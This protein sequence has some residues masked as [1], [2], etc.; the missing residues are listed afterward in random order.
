MVKERQEITHVLVYFKNHSGIWTLEKS[1]QFT[2]V[3]ACPKFQFNV[4]NSSELLFFTQ[5]ELLKWNYGSHNE[6]ASLYEFTYDFAT[7]PKFSRFSA[8]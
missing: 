3:G 1:A 6:P 5:K 7:M 4:K 2:L 8:D